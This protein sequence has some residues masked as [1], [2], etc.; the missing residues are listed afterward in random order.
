MESSPA[1]G[2]FSYGSREPPYDGVI[3]LAAMNRSRW[4]GGYPTA[5]IAAE[6]EYRSRKRKLEE[7]G[8]PG[9]EL[10]ARI[11]RECLEEAGEA[12]KGERVNLTEWA[13]RLQIARPALEAV[14]IM[15]Y[16]REPKTEPVPPNIEVQEAEPGDVWTPAPIAQRPEGLGRG[17]PK[18]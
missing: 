2:V 3:L 17:G 4:V 13:K 14:A 1:S 9:S 10:D 11:V 6:A 18:K 7:L 8:V 12:A 5:I 15:L 16:A